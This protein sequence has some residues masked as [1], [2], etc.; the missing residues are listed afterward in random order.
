MLDCFQGQV[1]GTCALLDSL[2][3]CVACRFTTT[4]QLGI[5]PFLHA[6]LQAVVH[7]LCYSSKN[8]SHRSFQFVICIIAVVTMMTDFL[9]QFGKV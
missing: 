1:D 9:Q 7:A 3:A 5:I 2:A 6:P 4:L 8:I